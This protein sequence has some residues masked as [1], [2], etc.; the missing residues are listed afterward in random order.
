MGGSGVSGL[1]DL[2][3][4]TLC[5]Q[6]LGQILLP[7]KPVQAV[8]VACGGCVVAVAGVGGNL[9]IADLC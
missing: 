9:H 6:V 2:G 1:P 5:S 7:H 3:L 4:P 8:A